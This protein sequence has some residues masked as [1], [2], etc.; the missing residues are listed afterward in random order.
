MALQSPY[1]DLI[2]DDRHV[3]RRPACISPVSIDHILAS[4]AGALV[5]VVHRRIVGVGA[6]LVGVDLSVVLH[7]RVGL[8]LGV[9]K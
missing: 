7:A 1:F 5:K 8:V 2:S 4:A 6:F 9:W 3:P